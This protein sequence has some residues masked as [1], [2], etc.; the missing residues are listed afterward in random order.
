[1]RCA[2]AAVAFVAT[3]VASPVEAL[4][5]PS[6]KAV[7][8]DYAT[9]SQ[10]EK[11][12]FARGINI[13]KERG[14]YDDLVLV[15]LLSFETATPWEE[16]GEVPDIA[17]RNGESRG[18]SFYPWHRE[19]LIA[20]EQKMQEVLEDD[21]FGIPYWNFVKDGCAGCDPKA[22]PMWSVFASVCIRGCYM[23]ICMCCHHSIPI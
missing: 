23:Y 8:R 16:K 18:P 20:F 5:S 21:T 10:F 19:F 2:Y 14:D 3:L 1:M 22:N 15:H 11:D 17:K 12:E 6:A 13:L 9:L 4:S 7:R